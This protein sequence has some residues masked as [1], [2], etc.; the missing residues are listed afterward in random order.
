M[1]TPPLERSVFVRFLWYLV[2]VGMFPIESS[3]KLVSC[4]HKIFG[5]CFWM[6]SCSSLYFL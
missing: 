5:L 3:L 4:R 1:D 2:Y 6:I